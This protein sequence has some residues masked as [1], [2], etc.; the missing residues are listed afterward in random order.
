MTIVCVVVFDRI[1]NLKE[2]LRCWSSCET[3]DAKLIIIHNL[4]SEKDRED[5]SHLCNLHGVTY[6]PHE[7]VGFDIGR[8]QDLCN[9]NLPG[10]PAEWDTV[11]WC[12]DD[13]LPMH[14]N[15]IHAFVNAL[16]DEV[17]VSAMEICES[18]NTR[19]V[20]AKKH[21]RTTGICMTRETAKLLTFP[22]NPVTT[23]E[24]CYHFEHRSENT[25]LDQV[26]RMGKRAAQVT[27]INES[28]LWDQGRSAQIHRKAEHYSTF[29]MAKPSP[30]KVTFICLIYNQYPQIV[31]SLINQTHK[32]WELILIHDGP[33]STGLQKFI[34]FTNDPRI[35]YIETEERKGDYGHPW[36]AWALNE[37]KEG[38]LSKQSDYV[39]ITNGDN[40]LTP[41]F[42]D[43][44]IKGFTD[45]R[46]II[47]TFCSHMI[48]SYIGWGIIECRL[49][50]GYVDCSGVMI[51]REVA[52]EVGWT[53][54]VSHSSDW[55]FFEQIMQKYGAQGFNRVQGCHLI[56][57]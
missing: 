7:N 6:I 20:R 33:N 5:Y 15:F 47:A 22:A 44:M 57:N 23:K 13:T 39:V 25:L 43:S 16:S 53:D 50:R 51:K 3:E 52:C 49:K 31:A 42:C 10:I 40:Q 2:W 56:H 24:Q 11:I 4:K 19:R 26:T 28:P 46:R 8:F 37:L 29:P 12:T 18:Q 36:R 1:D 34:D 35:T 30:K 54:I 41:A 38:R 32:E 27:T 17:A 9:D 45:D 55:T 48:H 14:P 21:I